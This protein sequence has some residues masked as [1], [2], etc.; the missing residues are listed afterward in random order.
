[1]S[2]GGRYVVDTQRVVESYS[3]LC[4][5]LATLPVD[6]EIAYAVKAA[7]SVPIVAA[8]AAAGAS[9]EVMHEAE[10]NLI[11]SIGVPA[12][13]WVVQRPTARP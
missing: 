11:G 1:M 6:V 12:S 4:E 13:R 7:A 2:V 5:L 3:A 9:F 8:L 10:M